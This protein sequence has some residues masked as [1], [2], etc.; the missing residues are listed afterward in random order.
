MAG[1]TSKVQ[2]CF[3]KSFLLAGLTVPSPNREFCQ[4]SDREFRK[5][6]SLFRGDFLAQITAPLQW[7]ALNPLFGLSW[8]LSG[9]PKNTLKW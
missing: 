8:P 9:G 1:M 4:N 3:P 7:G 6:N 2:M 5:Q